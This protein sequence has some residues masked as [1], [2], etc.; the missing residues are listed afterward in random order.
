MKCLLCSSICDNE[1]VLIEHYIY[2]HDVD[3][4]NRFFQKLFQQS[5][6]CSI[7]CKCLRCDDFLTTSDFKVK[8]D[9]LKHYND[10]QS[11]LFE[12]KSID[13]ETFGKTLKYS[14]SANKFGEYYNFKNS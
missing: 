10:R 4:N 2:Y 1:E 12:D 9:F 8:H 14:I 11:D 13:I 7:F 3:A 5:R 6:N